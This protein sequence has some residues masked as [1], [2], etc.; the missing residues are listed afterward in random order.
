MLI[1]GSAFITELLFS[2]AGFVPD[3]DYDEGKHNEKASD[4]LAE[5]MKSHA[6]VP[7]IL[8][9][10]ILVLGPVMALTSCL[11]P[12]PLTSYG[13]G[14][15]Y[16]VHT[17]VRGVMGLFSL[18]CFGIVLWGWDSYGLN[19]NAIENMMAEVG[20]I[21]I[22][23]GE[24]LGAAAGSLGSAI[25]ATE[26]INSD[27]SV[28]FTKNSDCPYTTSSCYE[29]RDNWSGQLSK[30]RMDEERKDELRTPLLATKVVSSR[31]L[32]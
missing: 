1:G 23:V 31:T 20:F 9:S 15:E 27:Y 25:T 22:F 32:L 10:M 12:E 3:K 13:R 26:K 18:I 30:V 17:K 5:V 2:A 4:K 11:R 8:G 14:F 7:I 29:L 19:G 24:Q 28:A 21:A 16:Q 6:S